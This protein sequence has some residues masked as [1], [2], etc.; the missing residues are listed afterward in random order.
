MGNALLDAFS[1]LVGMVFNLYALILALRF[2]MQLFRADYYNPLA[3]FIVKATDPVL[4]P[5]RKIV[6]SIKTYDTS[7]LLMAFVVLLCKLLLLKL[8]QTDYL[9]IAGKHVNAHILSYGLL[10]L[11]AFVEVIHLLFNVFIFAMIIQAILSW[12]PNPQTDSIRNLLSGIT[13]PVLRPIRKHLPPIAGF[14]LSIL[15]GIIALFF[16]QILVTGSLLSPFLKG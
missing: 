7:S 4:K 6:P 15:V 8:L 10:F 11:V 2:I 12:F 3:Q 9:P 14:D 16:L 5:V 13:E 1:F